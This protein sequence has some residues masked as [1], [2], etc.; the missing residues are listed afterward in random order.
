MPG[1][2]WKQGKKKKRSR[3]KR[4]WPS[5]RKKKMM[6]RLIKVYGKYKEKCVN[7]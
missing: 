2:K 1:K 6:L 5:D 3:D 7:F 4:S